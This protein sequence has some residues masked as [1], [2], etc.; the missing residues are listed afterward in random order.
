VP[1]LEGNGGW[2]EQSS[3][4]QAVVDWYGPTDLLTMAAEQG[5]LASLESGTARLIGGAL[6]DNK[7]KAAKASP[8]TYIKTGRKYPPFS[9]LHGTRDRVVPMSQSYLLHEALLKAGAESELMI[10]P[11]QGHGL[12][13]LKAISRS[14]RFLD[15]RLKP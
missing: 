15:E 14:V 7:D 2:N 5:S 11:N 3:A 8:I 9:I 10:V 12:L 4:V 6:Q 1:E 13:G